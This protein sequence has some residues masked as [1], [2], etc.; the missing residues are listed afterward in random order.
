MTVEEVIRAQL[1]ASMSAKR[2]DALVEQIT[3]A[4]AEQGLLVDGDCTT[5]EV[6]EAMVPVETI[7]AYGLILRLDANGDAAEISHRTGLVVLG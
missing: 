6:A 3:D 5:V 7:E 1:P 2:R 4:L